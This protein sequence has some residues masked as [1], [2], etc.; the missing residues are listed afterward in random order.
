MWQ[1]RPL[2]RA[3]IDIAIKDVVHLRNLR[4]AIEEKR[5]T[6]LNF[7][8]NVYLNDVRDASDEKFAT[9]CPNEIEKIFF[10]LTRSSFFSSI[11]CT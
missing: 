9:V 8:N 1:R 6:E 5:N 7:A 10:I 2:P 3:L 4:I 11:Y